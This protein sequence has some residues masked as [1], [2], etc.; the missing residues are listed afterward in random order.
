MDLAP[1]ERGF[2]RADFLDLN[3]QECS[4][5]ES[6]LAAENAIWLG[7]NTGLH[8]QGEC[9]ARMHLNQEQVAALLLLLSF[10][11]EHGRLP[12]AGDKIIATF[13]PRWVWPP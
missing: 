3:G 4:I 9:L 5:Q 8:H 2:Q 13:T 6:S 10:F 1:T 12:V 11:V 7:C